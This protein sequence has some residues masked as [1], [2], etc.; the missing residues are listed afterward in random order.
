MFVC[1]S[2]HF[3]RIIIIFCSSITMDKKAKMIQGRGKCPRETV[4][5]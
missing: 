5:L 4:S 1:E 2:V 3:Y